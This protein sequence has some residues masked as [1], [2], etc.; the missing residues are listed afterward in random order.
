[1]TKIGGGKCLEGLQLSGFGQFVLF[2]VHC[3]GQNLVSRA[4]GFVQLEAVKIVETL[5]AF[6]HFHALR[7]GRLSPLL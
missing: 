3:L 4:L 5:T 1:M 6:F 7:P 2:D